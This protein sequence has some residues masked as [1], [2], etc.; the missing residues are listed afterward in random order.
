M[1]SGIPPSALL[2]TVTFPAFGPVS[3]NSADIAVRALS[4][5][6]AREDQNPT[7]APHKCIRNVFTA[8][9]TR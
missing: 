5:Y 9:S 7:G 8:I 1:T 3:K 4:G 2:L 6:N